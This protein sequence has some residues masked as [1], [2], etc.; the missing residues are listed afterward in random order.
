MASKN[1]LFFCLIIV[2]ALLLV[3]T[4]SAIDNDTVLGDNNPQSISDYSDLKFNQSY[5]PTTVYK[6]EIFE[7]FLSVE[8]TGSRTYHNL[9]ILYPLPNGVELMMYPS[10]YENNSVWII[11][12]LYP[13]ERNTLT[14]VC[15]PTIANTTYE[16]EANVGGQTVT[17]L[18]VF[19]E[20]QEESGAD[21]HYDDGVVN[22][23][24]NINKT[25]LKEAANPIFLLLFTRI[26][27]PF[28]RLKY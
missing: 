11:D 27:I 5:T 22:Y 8:N 28:I 7:V 10:E 23:L 24:D 26:F 3:S 15:I 12:S 25:N 2:F 19:C 4:A 13:G 16:F 9:S 18:G 1:I 14:L 20:P 6:Q 21:S 17:D